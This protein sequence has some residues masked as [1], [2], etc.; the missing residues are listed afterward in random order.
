V[1]SSAVSARLIGSIFVEKGLITEEQLEHALDLQRS[2]GERLGEILVEQFAVERLDLAGALAEQWAEYERNGAAEADEDDSPIA[3]DP[4]GPAP[5][6]RQQSIAD[7]AS[8]AGK[9]PIGE[10]FVERGLVSAGQLDEALEEQRRTGGRL[11][12]ILVATGRLS[13]LELASALAD[14]WATFQ[15]LRPPEEP[16][17][18]EIAVPATRI[19]PT[20][21]VVPVA[22]ATAGTAAELASRIDALDAR[23]DDLAGASASEAEHDDLRDATTALAARIDKLESTLSTYDD[24]Q[25]DSLRARLDEALVRLDAVPVASDEWRPELAQVAESLQTRIERVEQGLERSS[26]ADELLQLRSTLDAVTSQIESLSQPSE[27]WRGEIAALAARIEALSTGGDWRAAVSELA[28]RVDLAVGSPEEWRAELAELAARLDAAYD[29]S[30]AAGR[31][32]FDALVK[33][34][35]DV[36]TTAGSHASAAAV[37]D[38]TERLEALASRVDSLLVPSEWRQ[39]VWELRARLESL[40]VPSEEWRDEVAS[41]RA[42]FESLPEP[43]DEWREQ[44]SELRARLESLPVPSEE[45]RDEIAELRARFDSLSTPSEEWREQVAQLQA[46]VDSLPAQAGEWRQAYDA[47][48]ERLDVGTSQLSERIERAYGQIEEAAAIHGRVDRAEERLDGVETA[49]ADVARD[50]GDLQDAIGRQAIE[51]HG[52]AAR[53]DQHGSREAE[54]QL[55]ARLTALETALA[56]LRAATP[57]AYALTERVGAVEERAAAISMHSAQEIELLRRELGEL[58]AA[59]ASAADSVAARIDDVAVRLRGELE[60]A[61]SGLARRDAVEA[62]SS[63]LAGA[64]ETATALTDTVTRLERR[65]DE[66]GA[67][68]TADLAALR[69]RVEDVETKLG[70][71]TGR[72]DL[73]DQWQD[74]LD[75]VEQAVG[76]HAGLEAEA[77]R[78]DIDALR[79]ELADRVTAIEAAQAK[80]KD[81]RALVRELER[82]ERR[83]DARESVDE[84]ATRAIEKTVRKGLSKL[85]EQMT[86]AEESYLEAGRKLHT[87]IEGLGRAIH[88]ADAHLDEDG[89]QSGDGH[90]GGTYI[91]FAPTLDG[92]RLVVCSGPAPGLGERVVVP[93]CEGEL[94]VT[95]VGSSPLPFDARACVYLE[96]A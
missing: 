6:V 52:L 88:A 72:S 75:H 92:Y 62:L 55:A 30:S 7:A 46:R 38:T 82:V 59:H 48:A 41:L 63:A 95:R 77:R 11:G 69:A 64:G 4:I 65:F 60:A 70:R 45:W 33:R 50:V 19:K 91:A 2:T 57:E 20:P 25:L 81:V 71:D 23:I 58:H 26:T 86:E 83:L 54:G 27:A 15:K 44:V 67:A 80:R 96:H 31:D 29:E 14:Q 28:E 32:L 56:E 53:A 21:E 61:A 90:A 3:S 47:L 51:L 1:D 79:V 35:E 84:A 13:R 40:P 49:H 9:R 66:A 89:E 24:E 39:Q 22:Q 12:E 68:R 17:D 16:D 74:R 73:L 36:E 8:A 94:V 87:A 42:R 34:V 78:A 37:A 76:D 18:T 10:I 43:S 5:V 85:G 93:S